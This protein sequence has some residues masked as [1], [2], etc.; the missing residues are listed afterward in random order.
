MFYCND[1]IRVHGIAEGIV[2]RMLLSIFHAQT[3]EVP[4]P[5][6]KATKEDVPHI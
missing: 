3:L 4:V 6:S 2:I 5:T 1:D